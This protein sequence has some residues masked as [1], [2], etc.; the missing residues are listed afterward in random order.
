MSEWKTYE[1]YLKSPEWKKIRKAVFERD[2][3]TCRLCPN[4]AEHAHHWRYP[5]DWAEDNAENC[6][7][8]CADCH[9]RTHVGKG[10]GTA[11][12]YVRAIDEDW[13]S[14]EHNGWMLGTERMWRNIA[15]VLD[16][17]SSDLSSTKQVS[18]SIPHPP[19]LAKKWVALKGALQ[20]MAVGGR[21][22]VS[23]K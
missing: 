1:D 19:D 10:A 17:I 7:V 5:Q 21:V 11:D 23:G 22:E 4:P 13:G 18:I 15:E 16:S 3:A 9:A 20:L 12:D 14:R 2:A 6:I 8:G